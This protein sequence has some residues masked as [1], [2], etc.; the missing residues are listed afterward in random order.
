MTQRLKEAFEA[1]S[2]L[3]DSEQDAVAAWL[4]DELESERQW[5]HAFANSQDA[6]AKLAM[7]A[8]EEY[9]AGRTQPLDE[10]AG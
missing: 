4:L 10:Q 5:D 6:L 3:P 1:I 2:V 8:L 7:E 9:R